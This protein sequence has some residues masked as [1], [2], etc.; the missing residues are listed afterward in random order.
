MATDSGVVAVC[1]DTTIHL[2]LQ[3]FENYR[4]K[5]YSYSA[6]IISCSLFECEH[7]IS[8]NSDLQKDNPGSDRLS[9]TFPLQQSEQVALRHLLNEVG[10]VPFICVKDKITKI[11]A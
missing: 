8:W 9:L 5:N 4:L 11:L 7:G 2:E 6:A 1:T 10:L 3:Q